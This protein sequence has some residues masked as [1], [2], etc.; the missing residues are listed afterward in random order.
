MSTPSLLTFASHGAARP[1]RMRAVGAIVFAL[2]SACFA[3]TGV[4]LQQNA[5]SQEEPHAVMD[6]RL[7]FRLLRRKRWLAGM[8][9][10]TSGF[11]FQ[12]TAISTGRL[13][14]V[15]PI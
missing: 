1:G 9:I 13:V 15:E 7:V 12:A 8:V 3:G 5:S 6:P 10:A 2:I 11:A 14:L 4:A